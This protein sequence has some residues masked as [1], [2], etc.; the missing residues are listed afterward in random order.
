M[1]GRPNNTIKWLWIG[2]LNCTHLFIEGCLFKRTKDTGQGLN[3][4]SETETSKGLGTSRERGAWIYC[5]V[6]QG[7]SWLLSLSTQTVCPGPTLPA[8]YQF[9]ARF[10][11]GELW[12][13]QG[14]LGQI[15]KTMW[16]SFWHNKM[17]SIFV[18]EL[19]VSKNN[20]LTNIWYP[21]CIMAW[22]WRISYILLPMTT[23]FEKLCLR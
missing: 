23:V 3:V 21:Q 6:W 20:T 16:K 12:T 15:S 14:F 5:L 4:F 9:P 10:R 2:S 19:A 22:I 17:A 8:S 7:L 13:K 11:F 18:V 1:H